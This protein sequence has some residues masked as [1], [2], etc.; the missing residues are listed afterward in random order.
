VL[1]L[2]P[3][4]HKNQFYGEPKVHLDGSAPGVALPS[5]WPILLRYS[6]RKIVPRYP[7]PRKTTPRAPSG[8]AE[9]NFIF[10]RE[11]VAVK[12]PFHIIYLKIFVF[13][14]PIIQGARAKPERPFLVVFSRIIYN[15]YVILIQKEGVRGNLGSPWRSPSDLS[16]WSFQESYTFVL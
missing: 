4:A 1:Y 2:F 5:E 8:L 10:S 14:V 16:W 9:S 15:I 7:L 11:E 3:R 13:D 12:F 6:L